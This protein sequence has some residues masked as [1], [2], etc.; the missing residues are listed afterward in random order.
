MPVDPEHWKKVWD[1]C[2][3]ATA[4]SSPLWHRVT[5]TIESADASFEWEGILTPLRKIRFA[6]GLIKGYESTVPGVPT[7]P[8]A[9]E[10]PDEKKIADYWEELAGR[11]NARFLVHLRPNSPFS[12]T[13]FKFII[14]TSHVIKVRERN[15][16]ITSHHKRHIKKA[17]EQGVRVTPA[18]REDDFDAYLEMYKASL[19]RWRKKPARV[20]PGEFFTK[21][22]EILIPAQAACFFIAWDGERPQAGA[23]ILYE[24]KR[25]IY[26]HG[27]SADNPAPGAGHFLHWKIM[28]DAEHRGIREY[29]FGPSPGLEG[30][31]RFKQSF[32][33]ESEK[34]ITVL[35]PA[36]AFSSYFLKRR[37]R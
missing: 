6:K 24:K 20:Y 12:K 29:E 35:G 21:V 10:V 32:G 9:Q 8:I 30:V 27:V 18:R 22:R 14:I 5:E 25:A 37:A 28:E 7:G 4:F 31:E 33:A 19:K 3:W 36:K 2:P 17:E 15:K 13:P 34:Q 23:L 26:W 16:R 11:T 1:A